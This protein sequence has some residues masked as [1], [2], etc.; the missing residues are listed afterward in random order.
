[1]GKAKELLFRDHPLWA[2]YTLNCGLI[3][4]CKPVVVEGEPPPPM[5]QYLIKPEG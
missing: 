3:K 1:M 4:G 2:K 5:K